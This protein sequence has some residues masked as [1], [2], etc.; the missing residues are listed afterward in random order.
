MRIEEI[1]GHNVREAREAAG[2]TQEEL[3]KK[4]EN[5]LGREWPRQTVSAAEK[6]GR[7]FTANEMLAISLVTKVSVGSLFNPPLQARSVTFSSGTSIDR[8]VLTDLAFS[9]GDPNQALSRA[10]ELLR[11]LTLTWAE[12]SD[13][14]NKE[15]DYLRQ[16]RKQLDNVSATVNRSSDEQRETGA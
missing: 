6:G 3:G 11:E 10:L 8:E 16:L 7:S 14:W 5:L 15:G 4:L 13:L 1:V 2:L 9:S 12:S